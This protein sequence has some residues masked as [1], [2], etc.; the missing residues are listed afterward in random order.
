MS[1]KH[2]TN[3]TGS[4]FYSTFTAPTT[5]CCCMSKTFLNK[6]RDSYPVIGLWMDDGKVDA[7]NVL[8]KW[9]VVLQL[10]VIRVCFFT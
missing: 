4:Q 6:A 3:V 7:V 2:G 8:G 10:Y 5:G 9:S 1:P